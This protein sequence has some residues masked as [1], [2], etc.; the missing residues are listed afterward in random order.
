V[1]LPAE[2]PEVPEVAVDEVGSRLM[3]VT[4]PGTEVVAPCGVTSAF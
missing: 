2:V 1:V 3:E 4:D